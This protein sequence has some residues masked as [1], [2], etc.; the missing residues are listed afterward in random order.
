M[1]DGGK[2]TDVRDRRPKIQRGKR[3]VEKL[4]RN[5]YCRGEI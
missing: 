4:W 2:N 3:D 1:I 5:T